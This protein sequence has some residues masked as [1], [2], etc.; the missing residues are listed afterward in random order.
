VPDYC[1]ETLKFARMER[2]LAALQTRIDAVAARSPNGAELVTLL[3][4]KNDLRTQL[5]LARR[6]S[7]GSI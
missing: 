1:V 2:E 5:E 3:R 4:R 6:D 7:R